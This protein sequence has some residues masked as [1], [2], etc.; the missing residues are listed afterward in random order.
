[1][2]NKKVN[3]F[4]KLKS[5]IMVIGQRY[6]EAREIERAEEWKGEG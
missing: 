1:M 2:Y 3:N 4:T 5:T 6:S